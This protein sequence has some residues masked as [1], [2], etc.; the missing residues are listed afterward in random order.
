M[1]MIL[2]KLLHAPVIYAIRMKD[3]LK[4]AFKNNYTIRSDE[5]FETNTAMKF[6][7]ILCNTFEAIWCQFFLLRIRF[8]WTIIIPILGI[9]TLKSKYA[10]HSSFPSIMFVFNYFKVQFTFKVLHSNLLIIII[11]VCFLKFNLCK[12]FE[13]VL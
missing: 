7:F 11:N 9:P 1:H 4:V 13:F 10:I 2:F 8:N 5:R 12:L 6:S 3:M